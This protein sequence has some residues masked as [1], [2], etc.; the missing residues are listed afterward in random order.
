MPSRARPRRCR[1]GQGPGRRRRGRSSRPA[2][3]RRSSMSTPSEVV[4][5][6]CRPARRRMCV[7]MRVV[8]LLPL[9]P[10]MLTVGMRRS[11]SVIQV[12][13]GP[14][15]AVDPPE[16]A[17]QAAAAAPRRAWSRLAHRPAASAPSAISCARSRSRQGNATIQWPGSPVRWMVT[18]TVGAGGRPARV[19]LSRC[20][21]VTQA[22]R[23]R[24]GGG[25][26]ARATGRPRRTMAYAPGVRCPY[27]VRRRPTVTSIL[28]VGS[29]RYRL[30]PSSSRTS[31]SRTMARV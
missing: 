12:G 19:P 22:A 20:R 6:T 4:V 18:G 2:S 14:A 30:G 5:P 7:S 25:A 26:M 23:S 28:T 31:T 16:N 24:T 9:V 29:S 21:R 8:V 17:L 3:T 27:Q 10:L 13:P 11:A 15:A 1:C